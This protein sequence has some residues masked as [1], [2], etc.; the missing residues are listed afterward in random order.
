MPSMPRNQGPSARFSPHFSQRATRCVKLAGLACFFS[1]LFATAGCNHAGAQAP[2]DIAIGPSVQHTGIKR[3]GINLSGQSFYDSGQMLRNLIFRNPGFEGETWQSI[4][5]CKSTTPTSCTDDNRW[6]QWPVDFLKGGRFEFISGPAKGATG[7]IIASTAAGVGNSDKGV[8]F[9]F[10]KLDHAPSPGDFVIIHLNLPGNAQAGWW[11]DTKT[12]GLFATEFKDLPPGTAGKQAL[13]ITANGPNPIPVT[14][15]F[16]SLANHSF[17]QLHG[18]FRLSFKAKAITGNAHIQANVHRFVDNQKPDYLNRDVPLT[19]DWQTYNLDFSVDE[20]GTPIGTVAVSLSVRDTTILLDDV[21]LTAK[22][23][24]DNPTAF[25]DEVVRTLRDLHPGVLRYMDNGTDFGSSIDNM[26]VSPF[27]RVRAGATT[28]LAAMEDI[29]IGL[30]EF[31]VLCQTIGAEPWYSMPAAMSP[32]E[33]RNLIEFLAGAASTPY[34]AKRAANGHPEPWTSAFPVIHLELGNEVW[35]KGSF[36]GSAIGDPVVFGK[37]AQEIYSAARSAP[38]YIP[39][40]FDLI[41]G[42]FT[43]SPWWTEKELSNSGAYDSIAIAPYLFNEFNDFSSKE[44]I[45]GSMFAEPEMLDSLSAGYVAQQAAFAKAATRPAKVTVYEV[46]LGTMQGAAPQS[47]ID[48]TVPSIGAGIDVANHMLLMM[49]DQG[50]TTQ[51]FFALPEFINHFSNPN[52]A[53]ETV[54]LWGAVVD[55]GGAT[56][57]RRPQFYAEQLVNQAILPTMLTTR[58]SGA[59]PTWNQPLSTNDKISLDGAH[60]IQ[61]FAFADDKQH[62]LVVFN[63]SRDKAQPVTFSGPV[64]PTGTVEISQ[65]TSKNITDNNEK[66]ATV[67][68]TN[69]TRNNFSASTP[70]SLPPF[71]MTVLRW[72]TH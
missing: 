27:G 59:N 7:P 36:Y 47:T 32:A 15:Y 26:I 56:N 12:P 55:M 46:N 4:L 13:R 71:S 16:D 40:K 34:G 69:T 58:L 30:E 38:S 49:R 24:P 39:A 60:I 23:S 17:V 67:A 6:T 9:N 52:G 61:S 54:P 3:L 8:T 1:L 25:R 70:F 65:L 18:A 2:T 35:N 66:S 50:I 41:L 62:S 51:A 20:Q 21:A 57:L 14:S 64:A 29:P 42:T 10:A 31:L 45:F 53:Q 68:P 37:R 22:A 44:A 48:S 43:T 72:T 11:V 33:A 63:L 19:N 28:Q 5:Q